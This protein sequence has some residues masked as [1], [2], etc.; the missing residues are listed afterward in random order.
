MSI[1]NLLRIRLRPVWMIGIILVVLLLLVSA[2]V[3]HESQQRQRQ[4]VERELQVINQLQR[5][6][7]Q[8]WY[9]QRQTD[10]AALMDD[11][12]LGKLAGAFLQEA[13]GAAAA[14]DSLM[15]RLRGLLERHNYTGVQLLDTHGVVRLSPAGQTHAR[16]PDIERALL[17]TAFTR[18]EAAIVPPRYDDTFEYP[19]LSVLVPLFHDGRSVAV[20]WLI[21][22]VRLSLYPILERWPVRRTT[23]GSALV[24][25]EGD[26][27]VYLSPSNGASRALELPRVPI[28]APDLPAVQAVMGM[29]GLYTGLR[30]DGTPMIAVASSLRGVSWVLLSTVQLGEA[31][32]GERNDF[33]RLIAPIILTLVTAGLV[34]I[35]AQRIAWRR[36]RALKLALQEQ[37]RMDGLTSVAN[38]RALNERLLYEWRRAARQQTPLSI[39]MIDIDHF[40]LY[41]D[42]YGHLRGDETL[43]RVA[44]L[45]SSVVTRS[46]DMVA[47]YG[48]EEFVVVMPD[49]RGTQALA[50]A[51]EICRVVRQAR[52]IHHHPAVPDGIVTV[53][54]G[55]AAGIPGETA[56][57]RQ[58][59][60]DA[61][62]LLRQAD[63]A[64]YRAKALGRSQVVLHAPGMTSGAD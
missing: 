17:G 40:K 49:T 11:D 10:A 15:I 45:V 52:I 36:E 16:A 37:V 60:D 50:M 27:A 48:G 51:E 33:L 42:A 4:H 59:D 31:I 26:E 18:A 20:I 14:R 58:P 62:V 21:M 1:N 56:A 34:L 2:Y 22:D 9:D 41:N 5:Q 43:K 44:S 25:R 39:L 46:V 6:S 32:H 29:R 12:T 63:L 8:A 28:A 53:S 61:T 38:R 23:A 30:Q 24:M 7:V 19:F 47:R 13:P 57:G 64:L 3:I 55:V 35:Y 54:I